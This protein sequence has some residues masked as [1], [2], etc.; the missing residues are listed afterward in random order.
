MS[1]KETFLAAFDSE[2]AK[3]MQVLH[4][5]PADKSELKPSPNLKSARELAFVFAL[6]RGLGL[7]VWH[8]AFANGMPS[9]GFPQSPETWNEVLA[10]IDKMHADFRAL[11]ASAPDEAFDEEV[12][13]FVGPK[14]MGKVKRNDGRCC[15]LM[16][17]IHHSRRRGLS[18][19]SVGGKAPGLY[20]PSADEP[21]F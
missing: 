19:R 20:G 2:H 12:T 14:T 9:G 15:I 8:D 5:Y 1:D 18:R 4:A 13:F 11:V 16:D 6:E 10:A 21:W 3:T 7:K 17:E